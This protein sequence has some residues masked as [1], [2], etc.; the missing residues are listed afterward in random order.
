MALENDKLEKINYK[1]PPIWKIPFYEFVGGKI[2][3][4]EF[5]KI[6]YGLTDL[7]SRI[8]TDAYI[9]LISFN[10]SNRHIYNDVVKL[11]LE[12]VLFEE[13]DYNCKFFALIGEFY[14]NIVLKSIITNSKNLP[15][16]VLN[17]FNG[18]HIQVKWGG[19]DNPAYDVEFLNEVIHLK[20][21]IMGCL[22]VLPSST[23][24]IGYAANSY[25]TLLMDDEGIVYISLQITDVIYRGGDFFE[26][27][28]KIFFGLDYG[29][30]LCPSRCIV[31]L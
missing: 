8:G 13:N 4:E 6:L 5:E 1:L 10:F 9:E 3:I 12:K 29:E 24:I 25:I 27:L 11:I 22:N 18:A 16:A 30:L 20:E 2:G 28:T 21:P 17:I 15:E 7:E 31:Y 26:T 14:Q 19:V 23:V